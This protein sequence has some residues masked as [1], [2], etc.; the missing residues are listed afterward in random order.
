MSAQAQCVHRL[1]RLV[2]EV[3][4]PAARA[5]REYAIE[6]QDAVWIG[7]P[8]DCARSLDQGLP[9]GGLQA[10]GSRIDFEGQC[11]RLARTRLAK[12]QKKKRLG[13]PAAPGRS[14]LLAGPSC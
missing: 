14:P 6:A 1:V 7:L 13:Y 11:R 2:A 4:S 9:R 5:I 12:A 3:L 8:V 10:R